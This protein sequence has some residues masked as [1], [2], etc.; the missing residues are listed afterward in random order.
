MVGVGL[1]PGPWARLR[2]IGAI[3]MRLGSRMPPRSMGS[4]ALG[5]RVSSAV[6]WSANQSNGAEG[7]HIPWPANIMGG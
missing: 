5:M 1:V 4:K 2:V 7:P 3:A 6:R